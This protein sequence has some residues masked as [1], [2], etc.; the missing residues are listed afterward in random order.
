[1]SFKVYI[2]ARY[3]ATRLPGKPLLEID[4]KPLIQHVYERAVASGA[5][6]VVIATDDER[7]AS[8]ARAFGATACMT[9]ADLASGSDRIAAAARARGEAADQVIVNVQGDEP[10]MPAAVIRQVARLALDA[11]CDIATVCE[12]LAD[13]Q[14]FDTNVVKVVRD[15]SQRAL[16]FSR[17]TIPWSRDEFAQG[18]Q[19]TAQLA[20]Y[21]RHV[22]IYA[23]RVGFLAR[24]VASPA[25]ALERLES[26]EQLRALG[27]GARIIAADALEACGIGVDTPA[28]LERLRR[29]AV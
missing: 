8:V 3:A 24:F 21:R 29:G 12:P 20:L 25:S 19:H 16:Y 26:L 2:P 4:G 9:S 7:I 11:E 1:M 5:A 28:D 27:F 10:R 22:G 23:Y 15:D 14:L 6:E 17:A 18:G 13:E